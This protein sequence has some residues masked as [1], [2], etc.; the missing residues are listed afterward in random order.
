[1]AHLL[2]SGD[3]LML[4][5]NIINVK[6]VIDTREKMT[7]IKEYCDGK[8]IEVERHKLD[9]GD[10]GIKVNG[11]LQPFTVERKNSLDEL[12]G[13]FAWKNRG[14]FKR[15]FERSNGNMAV[16]C[17]GTFENIAEHRYLHPLPPRN[18]LAQIKQFT[19]AYNVCFYFVPVN[20]AEFIVEL[21]KARVS[22]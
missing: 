11:V 6:I 13:N 14:R 21:L 20:S 4:A 16:V 18:Y 1:M 3:E 19:K 9:Y 12:A 15:E 10:Y 8:G 2:F 22:A 5:L 7:H 17:E